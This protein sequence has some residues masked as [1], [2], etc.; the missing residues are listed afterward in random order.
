VLAPPAEVAPARAEVA[1]ARH[2][3]HGKRPAVAPVAVATP[4]VPPLAP[5]P[6]RA[7]REL[8]EQ[9]A[10]LDRAERALAA[11]DATAALRLV[12]EYEARFPAGSLLQEATVVRVDSLS[13]LGRHAD[14]AAVAEAFLAS[15]PTS[16]Y[17]PKLRRRMEDGSIP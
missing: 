16:P 1:P 2:A 4:P 9:V 13:K 15:H 10:S 8:G 6:K 5:E 7:A 17:A 12:D 11:G 14:A 3:P